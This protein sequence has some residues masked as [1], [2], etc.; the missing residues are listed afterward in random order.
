MSNGM[1]STRI[2]RLG[3]RNYHGLSPGRA[4]D[5]ALKAVSPTSERSDSRKLSPEHQ[6]P[7]NTKSDIHTG[8]DATGLAPHDTFS[9]SNLRKSPLENRDTHGSGAI[10]PAMFIRHTWVGH[11]TL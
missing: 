10:A 11:L 2:E 7:Q 8:R 3:V 1:S 6:T 5:R 4:S 9:A